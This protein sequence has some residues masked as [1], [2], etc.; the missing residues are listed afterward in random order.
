[1][2]FPS[3][4]KP[5]SPTT[6]FS[7]TFSPD[8]VPFLAL[9][10]SKTHGLPS[11]PYLLLSPLTSLWPGFHPCNSTKIAFIKQVQYCQSQG[12]ITCLHLSKSLSDIVQCVF[13]PLSLSF[14]ASV[15]SYLLHFTPMWLA[16]PSWSPLLTL[17]APLSLECCIWS[18]GLTDLPDTEDSKI[19]FTNLDLPPQI[20]S[21]TPNWT[22]DFS[23]YTPNRKFKGSLVGRHNSGFLSSPPKLAL[24]PRLS[25]SKHI[26]VYPK[27][28]SHL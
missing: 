16:A 14:A 24:I 26:A 8:T 18:C 10:F 3:A 2:R 27:P 4:N 7:P 5:L 11:L 25:K 9:H 12:S 6:S 19:S 1:M 21:H 13:P 20:H 28:T 17:P 22:L 15:T 23:P